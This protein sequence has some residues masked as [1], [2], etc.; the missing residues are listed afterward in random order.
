L[1]SQGPE[2]DDGEELLDQAVGRVAARTRRPPSRCRPDGGDPAGRVPDQN[3]MM[4][5]AYDFPRAHLADLKTG[6]RGA[7]SGEVEPKGH[8]RRNTTAA[9]RLCLET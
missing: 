4:A 3:E 9:L 5:S 7:E 8:T 1:P 6:S 2:E